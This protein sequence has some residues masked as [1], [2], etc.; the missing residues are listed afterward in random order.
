[1]NLNSRK[2]RFSIFSCGCN[3][4]KS[5]HFSVAKISYFEVICKTI[6]KNRSI[7]S[8]NWLRS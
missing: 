8:A 1:M 4:I 5:F 7:S 2:L 6:A 3:Q